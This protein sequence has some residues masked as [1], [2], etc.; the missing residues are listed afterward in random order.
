MKVILSPLAHLK[1]KYYID[2]IGYEISGVGLVEKRPG[3]IL[4]VPDLFLIKQE[5]T[6]VETTLDEKSLHEFMLEKMQDEN[7]PVENLKLW[8]HSHV[9]MA[10]FWSGVDVATRNTLDTDQG[11]EN[12]WLS[13]VGNKKGETKA[14]LDVFQ[15]HRLIMDDIPVEVGGMFELEDAIKLEIEEKVTVKYTQPADKTPSIPPYSNSQDFHGFKGQSRDIDFG[16]EDYDMPLHDV[17]DAGFRR[18]QNGIY[19]PKK[20]KKLKKRNNRVL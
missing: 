17:G 8:W 16:D 20:N 15:P 3:G 5:V 12:W 2:N 1:M 6:G 19:L 13:I 11:E 18:T 4:Y 9:N 7:F 14:C 10:V